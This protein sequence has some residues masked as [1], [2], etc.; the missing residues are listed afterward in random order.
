MIEKVK[1]ICFKLIFASYLG[2][3][4]YKVFIKAYGDFYRE[5][6]GTRHYN[7]KLFDSISNFNR[8]FNNYDFEVCFLNIYGNVLAFMPFGFLYPLVAKKRSA[9]KTIFCGV[10]FSASIEVMQFITKLG[11]FDVDDI[12]L[13]SIGVIFGYVVLLVTE[14]IF[15]NSFKNSIKP[16]YTKE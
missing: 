4:I 7:L 13:N 3:L 6:Y 14:K 5:P 12:L 10:L 2:V 15:K 11:V 16:S 8:A 1:K 9:W